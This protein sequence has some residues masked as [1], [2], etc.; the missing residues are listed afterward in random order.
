[1]PKQKDYHKPTKPPT[2]QDEKIAAWLRTEPKDAADLAKRKAYI[3]ATT[4]EI[5]EGWPD[6][7]K[8]LVEDQDKRWDVPE[9]DTDILWR[10]EGD[11]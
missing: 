4:A 9:F 10:H 2:P 6:E 5:H 8:H 3:A 11:R 1:M 7:A